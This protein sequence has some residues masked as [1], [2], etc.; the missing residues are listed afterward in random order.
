MQLSHEK[1]GTT[2]HEKIFLEAFSLTILIKVRLLKLIMAVRE[3]IFN[4]L[5]APTS[6]R[7]VPLKIGRREVSGSSPGRAS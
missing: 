7:V 5:F 3:S 4:F 2:I 6:G 1:P